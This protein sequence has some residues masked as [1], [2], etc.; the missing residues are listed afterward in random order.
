MKQDILHVIDEASEWLNIEGIVG[1]A[2]G[3][4]KGKECIDVFCKC[5]PSEVADSIPKKFKGYQVV[6]KESGGEFKIQRKRRE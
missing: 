4:K 5:A 3:Y 2:P 6:I 1:V